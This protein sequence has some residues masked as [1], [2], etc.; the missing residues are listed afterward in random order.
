VK[1]VY[2]FDG[3]AW[4]NYSYFVKDLVVRLLKPRQERLTIKEA[5][6]HLWFG[7]EAKSPNS[8]PDKPRR[9]SQEVEF[10]LLPRHD[11]FCIRI[12]E[13]FHEEQIF[14]MRHAISK[15]EG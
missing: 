14:N 8:P 1:G 7:N 11:T 10:R 2:S 13:A 9:G 5:S 6:R 15:E 3:E 12:H 4:S